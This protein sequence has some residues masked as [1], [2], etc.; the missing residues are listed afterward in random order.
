MNLEEQSWN[1]AYRNPEVAL[2]L[3]MQEII[4]ISLL[5][6]YT[7]ICLLVQLNLTGNP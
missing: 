6:N 1:Q 4:D 5:D 2:E 3:A 7:C